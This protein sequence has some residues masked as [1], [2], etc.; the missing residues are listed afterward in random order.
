MVI[1][2]RWYGDKGGGGVTGGGVSVVTRG[3]W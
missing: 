1:K 2:G 3:G